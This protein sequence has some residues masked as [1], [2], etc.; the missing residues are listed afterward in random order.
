VK[1]IM[2]NSDCDEMIKVEEVILEED[3]WLLRGVFES[4]IRRAMRLRRK[5]CHILL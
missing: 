1:K 3:W 5:C 4:G 2:N